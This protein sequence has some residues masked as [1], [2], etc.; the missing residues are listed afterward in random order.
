MKSS[1]GSVHIHQMNSDGTVGTQIGDYDW[2]SGWTNATFYQSG[3][4]TYLIIWKVSNAMHFHEMN[5]DGTVGTRTDDFM[6]GL[7][8]DGWT[9]IETY[10]AGGIPRL[11]MLQEN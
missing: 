4:K 11:F 9:T 2:S 3:P 10:V 5:S 8:D 6:W 1:N 7:G